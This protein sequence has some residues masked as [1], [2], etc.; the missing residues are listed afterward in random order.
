MKP[1]IAVIAAM[2]G[3]L[4]PAMMLTCKK[5]K[6]NVKTKRVDE[7]AGM[8]TWK[9]SKLYAKLLE[10]EAAIEDCD[11]NNDALR[12]EN[13]ELGQQLSALLAQ[14]RTLGAELGESRGRHAIE[15]VRGTRK[16]PF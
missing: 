16:M 5:G 11:R 12:A 6:W 8:E 14:C 4:A 13:E 1:S 3:L 10:Q 15:K 2:G 7:L 9:R